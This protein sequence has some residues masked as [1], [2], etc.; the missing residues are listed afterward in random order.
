M[1]DRS[2]VLVMLLLFFFF[3]FLLASIPLPSWVCLLPVSVFWEI[4][5][6]QCLFCSPI[7]L[8]LM[9]GMELMWLPGWSP[10]YCCVVPPFYGKS[11]WERHRITFDLTISKIWPG[12]II[13][14][15]KHIRK[16][17]ENDRMKSPCLAQNSFRM[18]PVAHPLDAKASGEFWATL[19]CIAEDVLY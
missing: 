8:S 15:D 7:Y 12:N 5:Q 4:R 18:M 10:H 1:L 11:K 17:E 13:F 14:K 19:N 9:P 3:F 6:E 2:V 16:K